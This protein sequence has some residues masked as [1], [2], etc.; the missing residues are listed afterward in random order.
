MYPMAWL[1]VDSFCRRTNRSVERSLNTET[2][3]TNSVRHR[4]MGGYSYN[5]GG[6]YGRSRGGY[7]NYQYDH[8]EQRRRSAGG[9]RRQSWGSDSK[10]GNPRG[11]NYYQPNRKQQPEQK[12]S[13]RQEWLE[14]QEPFKHQQLPP[15]KPNAVEAA[16]QRSDITVQN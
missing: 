16:P 11:K 6:R 13:E 10:D 9:Y 5:R 3:G 8:F 1:D 12:K 7:Q 14:Q 15:P 2:F 4:H